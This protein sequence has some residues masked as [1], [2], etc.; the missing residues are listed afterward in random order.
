MKI[1][2][3]LFLLLAGIITGQS[4]SL[5]AGFRASHINSSYPG[6]IFPDKYYWQ[7]AGDYF[8]SLHP[9]ATAAGVWIVSLYIE[10]GITQLNFPNPGGNYEKVW[11]ISQDQN[12]SCLDYFDQHGLKVWLQVEPGGASVDT[13]IHII[14]NKYGHH[15]CV[16]G[17]GVDVEWLDTHLHSGGRKV[18]DAEAE[19]WEAKVKSF[20]PDYTLFLKHY[21]QNRMP[22]VYR[23][24]L[25]FVDDSQM[26]QSFNQMVNEFKSWGNSFAG[27][28]V[29]FQYGYPAD[30]FW[31]NALNLPPQTI[32]AKLIEQVPNCSAL[33]WVDFSIN[34]VF[35]VTNIDETSPLP[36]EQFRLRGNYP[37]PFNPSTNI[38]FDV[39]ERCDVTITVNNFLGE[40]ILTLS[41][42]PVSAGRNQLSI[43]FS[44]FSSGVYY[45]TISQG[46]INLAGKL[47]YIK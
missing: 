18:T 46:D 40:T 37:N 29:A 13:L 11:F 21:T 12:E 8:A 30:R 25:I 22:S 1:K 2:F 15:P 16:I 41:D 5:Y 42:Y 43:N 9:G 26:F 45:Y 27:S 31:W 47:V 14:L 34:D 32:G 44:G 36:L 28:K 3:I 35:P 39:P 7:N 17:F 19:R 23:G 38:V 10:N 33:F 24:D 4:D 6:N 20:N